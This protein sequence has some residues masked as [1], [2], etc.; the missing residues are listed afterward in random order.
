MLPDLPGKEPLHD[1]AFRPVGP[2]KG[3]YDKMIGKYPEFMP[4]PPKELKRKPIDPEEEDKPRF[5]L[6]YNL[7]SQP[8]PSVA[9]N[10]RNLKASYPMAFTG[11]F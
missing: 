11:R 2:K 4:N 9:T 8:T 5:K 7:R 1:K 10:Y 3:H 6:T